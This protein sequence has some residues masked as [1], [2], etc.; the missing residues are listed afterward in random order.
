M[1]Q[2]PKN[3]STTAPVVHL[4]TVGDEL[5]AGDIVDS[6][7]ARMAACARSLGLD[8]RRA[9][10]VRDRLREIAGVLRKA[11]AQADVCLV[12][13]G[14]GPTTDDL[15]TAAVADAVR[16]P[17]RRDPGAQARLEAKFAAMERPMPET[18]LKQA[19]FPEGADI[20]ENPIGTA[21]GHCCEL[22]GS[23]RCQVYSMPGVPRELELMLAEQ[24]VPRLRKRFALQPVVRRIY[25]VLGHGESSV[26][27]RIAP[28]IE[29]A[30]E[31]S[32]G[33]AA[34]IVHYRA[35]MPEVSV[36]LEA[37]RGPGGVYATQEELA[38]LDDAMLEALSPGIYGIGE[39][40]LVDRVVS[41]F[42]VSGLRLATAES[43]TGGG[44]GALVTSV[45]GSS[46]AYRGG[47]ISYD[48]QIKAQLLG[49][50]SELLVTYGAVSEPVARAMARG[51]R[52]RLGSDLAVGITGLAGPGGGTAEKPVGTVHIAIVDG[53]E[54]LHKVLR[55][56]GNRNTIQ[57]SAA[58]WAL[59]L[60]WDR[61]VARGA[62]SITDRDN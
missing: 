18:N 44:L 53:F 3:A 48:N 19:D 29:A 32:P 46:A 58:L 56:R 4:L 49:V 47:I 20:L 42:R 24:V 33:L 12:S 31:R 57:R 60:L 39:A 6:N 8:V 2:T 22:P 36:V 61:L 28:I 26:A 1:N 41:S 25:R 23:R 11:A 17:L 15:T 54:T 38:S 37:A 40:N 55:L 30:R 50:P 16:R 34:M 7:K 27:T 14:L 51:A 13:G 59:K 43:C 5:L 45:A 35:S 9:L 52:D 21:E 10:T 62:A